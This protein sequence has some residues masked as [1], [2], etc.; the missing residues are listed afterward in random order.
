MSNKTRKNAII[1]LG[2]GSR[3]PAAASSMVKV[4]DVLRE[5][6]DYD[7]VETCYMSRNPPFFADTLKKCVKQGATRVL[8]I[9][10]F[11]H[12][13][14]HMRLDIPTMM[15]READKYPGVNIVFG[16]HLGFDDS[17]IDLVEKRINESEGLEDIRDVALPPKESFPLPMGEKEFVAM[18]PDEAKRY[19][20]AQQSQ[21]AKT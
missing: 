9:P 8:L 10:Y 1:L 5:K 18:T 15:K 12:V 17:L 19:R 21:P 3:V 11:L 4:A 14:L 2:H 7:I 6:D 13:G 20:E 16:P